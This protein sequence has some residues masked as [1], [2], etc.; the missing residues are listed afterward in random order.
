MNREAIEKRVRGIQQD[1]WNN[2]AREHSTPPAIPE[3]FDP[4]SVAKFLGVEV[5]FCRYLPP[6]RPGEF[7][8]AGIMD[9]D[10]NKIYL[11]ESMTPEVLRYTL[12]H[13]LAHFEMHLGAVY[14]R[15]RPVNGV[16]E[17]KPLVEREADYW[18][19]CMLMPKNAL[20]R[21]FMNRFGSRTPL[22][23]TEATAFALCIHDAGWLFAEPRGSLE[24]S[25]HVARAQ[26]YNGESFGSLCAHFVVSDTAI[27]EFHAV[28]TH[29]FH[30]E[31]THP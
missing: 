2:R 21:A 25:K 3:L 20:L 17:H 16:V 15:D 4:F 14:H 24:F 18:A 31:V 13:E 7:E 22:A 5:V 8:A 12:A 29:R 19:A 9:R 23:L 10:A 1:M 28:L 6:E 27:V 11:V 26:R 30:L